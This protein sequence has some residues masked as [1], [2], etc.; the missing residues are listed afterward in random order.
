[1]PVEAIDTPALLLDLDVFERNV[2][3]MAT[4]VAGTRVCLRPHAKT[5]K[6]PVIVLKQI[7]MGAVG[8]CVQKVSEAEALF[9]GGVQDIRITNEIVGATKIARLAALAKQANISV[10]VDDA[11]NVHALDDMALAFG[12]RLPVLVEIDVGGNR[13]GVDPGEAAVVLAKQIAG[14]RGLRFAGIQAYDGPAQHIRSFEDR[15]RASQRAS[16]HAQHVVGLL[17]RGTLSCE[18]VTG[19]GTGTFRFEL[20]SGIFTEVQPGSYIFMDLDYRRNLEAS[21]APAEGFEQ[22]LFVYASIMSR[23]VR[24]RAIVDA[25]EKAISISAGLPLVAD[26]PDVEY[27]R[28]SVE[29]GRL[30]LHDEHRELRIGDKIRLVPGYCDPTVNLF[31]WY[32]CVRGD[33]VEA[34]WPITARGALL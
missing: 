10:C 27:S 25:G 17:K 11:S 6:C 28:V 33:R 4:A 22:A 3:C 20:E 30:T 2:A 34:L 29:H 15:R 19:G 1:M 21:G 18:T 14:S 5:S 7:A 26:M 9:D 32:V 24:N 23:P 31:E 16:E 12:I 8:A 13:C